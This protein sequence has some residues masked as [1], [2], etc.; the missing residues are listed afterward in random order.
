MSSAEMSDAPE[1]CPGTGNVSDFRRAE[2]NNDEN[3][4]K[5]L[6]A[7]ENIRR[8]LHKVSSLLTS[9]PKIFCFYI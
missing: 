3:Q 1:N 4:R 9:P 2:N 7:I 8:N 5:Y 6:H